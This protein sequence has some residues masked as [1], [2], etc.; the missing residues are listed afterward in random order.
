MVA[1]I[2]SKCMCETQFWECWPFFDSL[3]AALEKHTDTL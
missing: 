1:E 3:S 2:S